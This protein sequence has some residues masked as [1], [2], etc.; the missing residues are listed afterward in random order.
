MK[1]VRFGHADSDAARIGVLEDGYVTEVSGVATLA[2]L[3]QRSAAEIRACLTGAAGERGPRHELAAV[4]ILPP[5]DG[6]CE[7]W[8][9]GVTYQISRQARVADS[10]RA[11]NVYDQVYDADRPEL[12][13]KSAAWRAVGAGE[14]ISIRADSALDVPEPELAV[15]LNARGEALGYT[16]CNDVSSRTIEGE[17]PLYLPQAKVYLGGCAIGPAITPAW[18]IPEPYALDIGMVIRRDGTRAWSGSASTS[19]MRRRI[20][21]LTEFLF[22]A[23]AFPDGVILATGTCLVPEP[24]FTLEAGDVVTIDI[25]GVGQLT[26]PV[27]RG[28][29]DM[30]WVTT[31]G[32][33]RRGAAGTTLLD[34]TPLDGRPQR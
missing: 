10:L 31:A 7:V 5:I 19:A 34:A 9:A 29:A 20:D 33:G 18:E 24:P 11:Q 13:F 1:I 26:N 32:T 4:R 14:P 8:A 12:F 16:I 15:V 17:N 22:R 6:R 30:M 28:R 2:E 21:T 23:D 3:W 27:V 25:S